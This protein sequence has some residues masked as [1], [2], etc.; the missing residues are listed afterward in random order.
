[1]LRPLPTL[2]AL[3]SLG[4]ATAQNQSVLPAVC[5]TL[6]GN[7]ALS[8][9]FRW[10]HGI[11]Q[12]RIDSSL[13]PQGFLGKTISGIRMRRPTF[14]SEP[15]YPALQRTMT[16]RGGFQPALASTMSRDLAGNRP[17][18]IA[19]LFGPA[20]V[21]VAATGGVGVGTTTGAEF[22]TI[23]L[24]TPL[25][26][27]AGTL[28]LEF[29]SGDAPLAI[30]T[31]NWVDAVWFPG[32]AETGYAVT[33]GDG[34]CTTRATPSELVWTGATGPQVGGTAS[35]RLT[36]TL[37]GTYVYTWFGLAPESRAVGPTYFGW[38]GSMGALSPGLAG[39]NQWAP[40]DVSLVG[41][42]DAGGGY[43]ATFPLSSSYAVVGLKIGV[44]SAWI[45]LTRPAVPLSISNGV[46]LVV[47]N[48]AVGNHCATAYFPSGVVLSPWLPYI[49]QMPVLTLEHN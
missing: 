34:S 44:Q 22:V 5:R 1:M 43:S 19:V 45:D 21:A 24:T 31:T 30:A 20:P 48:V 13:L 9:P 4:F 40:L 15:A 8:L 14:L 35:L 39:C 46:M 12:V 17:P 26:V 3:L 28:F 41:T 33:V 23:P 7:A 6:P 25:L 11:L 16:V 49:G 42:S 27:V 37:P 36:G 47:G 38:G 29:E 18:G 10:S 2:F 32:G